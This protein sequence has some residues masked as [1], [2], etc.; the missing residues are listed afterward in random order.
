M[1]ITQQKTKSR[2]IL[3][4]E[5]GPFR[6]IYD[7]K[8]MKILKDPLY[9]PII[10]A[11]RKGPMT[12]KELV[13]FYNK[14]AQETKSDKTLYRYLKTL[15]KVDLVVPAGQRLIFG[16]TATE[17]L[18]SRTATAFLS[19]D[20]KKNYWIS[21]KAQPII[22][23]MAK[24]LAAYYKKKNYSTDCLAKFL[25]ENTCCEQDNFEKLIKFI[26]TDQMELFAKNWAEVEKLYGS[27]QF[28]SLILSTPDIHQKIQN[29]FKD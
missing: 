19:Q 20:D 18:Y 12:V 4:Y 22:E 25:Y 7:K 11:L 16:K 15:E 26:E 10:K 17:T 1:T 6:F 24:I 23:K 21:K 3:T 5:P 9:Y 2:D 13:K 14:D 29:C 8:A 28:L 27:L